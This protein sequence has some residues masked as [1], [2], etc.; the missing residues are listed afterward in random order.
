VFE[1]AYYPLQREKEG[2]LTHIRS[3]RRSSHCDQKAWEATK[4]ATILSSRGKVA[5]HHHRRERE[6][7]FSSCLPKGMGDSSR[8]R[9]KGGK[10]LLPSEPFFRK[11]IGK[12]V[13]EIICGEEEKLPSASGRRARKGGEISGRKLR[14]EGKKKRT[15]S[16]APMGGERE[17]EGGGETL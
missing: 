12:S 1:D 3:R 4:K 14:S 10:N 2:L 11:T 6:K 7:H 16:P 9:K 5:L 15:I 8:S 13:S 17:G